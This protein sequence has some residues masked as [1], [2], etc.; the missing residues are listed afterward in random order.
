[1][2]V[3]ARSP[4]FLNGTSGDQAFAA[5][6]IPTIAGN[7]TA[8]LCESNNTNITG[9][10]ANGC[11]SGS[12]R[13]SAT[14]T[15]SANT[16]TST[17]V[18]PSTASYG[19]ASVAL[20]ATVTASSPVNVGTVTF[21]VKQGAT[22]IGV[23]TTSGTV[24]AGNASV[25]YALPTGTPAGTYS[26]EAA[27]SG[28]TGFAASAGTGTLTINKRLATWT[29][30]PASKTYGDPDPSP[31]TTGSGN[32]I[33]SDGVTATYSRVAGET[34]AGNPYHITATL[35]ATVPGALDN[36]TI[37]NSGAD[38][39]I[40]KR[41]AT[42]TT[43]PATKTYGDPDPSPLTT[44]SGNFVASDGVTATYSRVAG[45]TVAGN[46]YHI[47]ATLS[48]TVPGALD[49]YTI[50]NSG[51]DFTINKRLV[52]WTTQPASKTYGDADPN[53]LTTGSGSNF[54]A[55]D[56]VTATYNRVAGETVAGNPYHITA[57]LSATVPGA[58]DNYTIANAG[59]D[60][61]INKRLATWTT[62][63]A[64]KTYGDAD[65][66][67]LTTG[68]GSNFIA[69]DGVTATYS[70]VAG[71]TVAGNPYH[72]TATLTAAVADALDNY[73][74][75][76]AGADFTINKR[77]ATWTTQSA[78]KTYGDADPNPLT[79]GSGSNFIASD[80]VTATY[81]R[82]AGETV[83]GNPYH[84]TATLTAAVA[85]ALDNYDITNAGADFT[86]NKRAA[87]WTTQP[88]NVR[89]HGSQSTN[90]GLWQQ[91]HCG[92]RCDGHIQPRC[93]RDRCR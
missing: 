13:G 75:T 26:I 18:S 42:W 91:L 19:D 59:A 25:T 63:P 89:R 90:H 4:S 24:S 82:V 88:A 80:G 55:S 74:I 68:S 93:G 49:N 58:L 9:A 15:V 85:D 78:S 31:L 72:I 73:D 40:N 61:T 20:A 77:A 71:E 70:R 50:T 34:V 81:S 84:I 22:T 47:T 28:G 1:M 27:F 16:A 3:D 44:G 39:T 23:S 60:F 53:P 17:A 79:T 41:L 6:L 62:Q 56:G 46:P 66:N 83:A 65:P 51:A 12:E 54:I 14:F 32:F 48:A 64:S 43:Q 7:W 29:T 45:E 33:A 87:T 35:S 67:P 69:S 76:N 2:E 21:T 11:A 36:Y 52:T 30:Q 38:F 5:T 8:L 86:I 37:T 92:R 10:N 57:T